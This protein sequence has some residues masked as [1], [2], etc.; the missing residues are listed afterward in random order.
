M[1]QVAAALIERDNEFLIARRAP[2]KHLAGYWEFPGG[3]I[4][5]DETP[6]TCLI[7]ELNE[8]LNVHIAVL[9]Y[10]GDSKHK[11]DYKEINL[12][13]YLCRI[14]EGAIQLNDHDKVAWVTLEK[15]EK[16]KLAPADIPILK[17]Y[18]KSRN[19]K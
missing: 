17:L 16:Y 7:R 13:A 3:K 15:I 2:G 8:E 9:E 4:E 11:Y 5:K 10:L 18:D 1:I 12:K 14:I 19:S 6:E